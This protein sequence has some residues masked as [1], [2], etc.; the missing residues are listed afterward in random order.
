[1]R[2]YRADPFPWWFKVILVVTRLLVW[3]YVI[4]T[5]VLVARCAT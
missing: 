3:G 1:V 5:I 4:A 2:R